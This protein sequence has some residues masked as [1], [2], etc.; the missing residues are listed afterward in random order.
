METTNNDSLFKLPTEKVKSQKIIRNAI[1]FGLPKIGKTSLC[2]NDYTLIIS[3]E[4]NAHV[5]GY[6]I[7]V[8][9]HIKH[10]DKHIQIIK[11]L[12]SL[13]DELKNDTKFK[14]IA[15]DNLSSILPL[16]KTVGES[17]YSKTLLGSNWFS[18]NKQKYGDLL[19]LPKGA[20][21]DYLKQGYIKLKEMFNKSGKPI[22]WLGHIKDK[23]VEDNVNTVSFMEVD[24]PGSISRVMSKDAD[25]IGH[26]FRVGNNHLVVS[27]KNNRNVLTGSNIPEL[28][29]NEYV[30]SE[31]K[32]NTIISYLD[33]IMT[34]KAKPIDISQLK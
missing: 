21:Y 6:K 2:A 30:I 9:E 16:A 25:I 5:E 22:I 11:S 19:N 34:L 15:I 33:E 28:A 10:P 1:L 24:I 23:Y 20:G 13:M 18:E 26:L 17:I 27:F 32:D 8:S 31:K 3:F 4:P 12:N 14:Y 7:D 29:N